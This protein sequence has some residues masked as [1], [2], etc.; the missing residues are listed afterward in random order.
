MKKP[1]IA[2]C[3]LFAAN[4]LRTQKRVAA[5]AGHMQIPIRPGAVPD[6]RPKTSQRAAVLPCEE[7]SYCS[8]IRSAAVESQ[9]KMVGLADDF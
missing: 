8:S 5:I 9:G 1:L 6:A 3:A 4:V 2:V 7:F